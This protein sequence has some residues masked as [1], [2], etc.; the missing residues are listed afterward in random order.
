MFRGDGPGPPA[1]VPAVDGTARGSAWYSAKAKYGPA[2]GRLCTQCQYLRSRGRHA[3][4]FD[5]TCSW[6]GRGD[7]LLIGWPVPRTRDRPS[8]CDASGST[9]AMGADFFLLP[10]N[11]TTGTGTLEWERRERRGRTTTVV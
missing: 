7:C 11:T 6:H 2:G 1:I 3:P 10:G 4:M 5:K 8:E 9:L